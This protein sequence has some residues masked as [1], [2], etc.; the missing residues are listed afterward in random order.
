MQKVPQ[1]LVA[2]ILLS[3]CRKSIKNNYLASFCNIFILSPRELLYMFKSGLNFLYAPSM[4]IHHK[5]LLCQDQVQ[6]CSLLRH[7]TSNFK[8]TFNQIYLHSSLFSCINIQFNS[9]ITSRID[10]HILASW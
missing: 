8:S 9:F 3:I 7:F 2:R 5:R 1:E 10:F 4:L 6:L